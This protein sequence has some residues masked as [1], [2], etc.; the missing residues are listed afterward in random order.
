MKSGSFSFR[1]KHQIFILIFIAVGLNANTLFNDYALDDAV[2]MTENRFVA[3]G[4]NGISEILTSD[5]VYG[6]TSKE[7]ILTGVRYRPFSLIFF[8]V[9]HQF[10]G[11]NP[12]V[13][14]LINILLFTLLTALLYKLLQVS[15]FREQNQYLAFVTCLLFA[16]HPIH[17]EVI[18]NV[19]S[20]DELIAFIFILFS[21]FAIIKVFC[22]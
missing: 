13:S 16:V 22:K 3:K 15:V 20:R 6:Y 9:E 19:K 4:L 7:N 17:T 2:V 10:F 8:A 12:L 18:A 11:A 14:H 21:S 5:Y 1:I